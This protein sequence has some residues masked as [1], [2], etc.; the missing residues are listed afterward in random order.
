MGQGRTY[1]GG[2]LCGAFQFEV[3]G[4]LTNV[5]LCHCDLC[6]KANGS[7]YSANCR[8]PREMFCIT[9][10]EGTLRRYESSPGAWRVFCGTCGSPAYADVERDKDHIRVRLGTLERGAQAEITAHVWT[11]SKAAWDTIDDDL[12]CY[13]EGAG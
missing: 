12:A 2:C 11:G 7:A 6:R 3:E 8:V 5:R 4:P 1:A 13:E 9:K 10:D